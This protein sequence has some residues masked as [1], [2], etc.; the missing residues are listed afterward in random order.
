MFLR[1]NKSWA[2]VTPEEQELDGQNYNLP[3][4]FK[5]YFETS[6]L[7]RKHSSV[8]PKSNT[9]VALIILCDGEVYREMT[10]GADE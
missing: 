2:I 6:H 7:T 3:L 9:F 8:I 10:D 1:E 5:Q 4:M